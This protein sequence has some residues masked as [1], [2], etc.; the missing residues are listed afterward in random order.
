MFATNDEPAVPGYKNYYIYTDESGMHGSK[1]YAFGSL[2]IPWERRGDLWRELNEIRD[3]HKFD[4]EIKWSKAGNNPG[5]ACAVVDWFFERK[6]MMFHGLIVPRDLVDMQHHANKDEAQRKHFTMLI[7]NKIQRFAKTGGKVYRLRV[8]NLP[9]RYEKSDEVVHKVANAQ[10]KQQLG[11]PLI[12]DVTM[13]DSKKTPG[14]QIAD[15]L[16]GAVASASQGDVSSSRKLRIRQ[17]IAKHLGWKDL[18]HD[19]EPTET[20]FNIWMFHD[21]T[22]SKTRLAKTLP[23]TVR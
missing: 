12:H 18:D 5:F 22:A 7:Q 4:S 13:C 6:W 14:I 23:V 1:C 2:W 9:W 10:L 21:P 19:T 3:R 17:R 16:L 11:T 20:K 8:D 15:L